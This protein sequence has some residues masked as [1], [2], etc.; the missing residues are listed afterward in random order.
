MS[1]KLDNKGS[2][3]YDSNSNAHFIEKV[4]HLSREV[5]ET[6]MGKYSFLKEKYCY[7]HHKFHRTHEAPKGT[8][9]IYVD[10][11]E[12]NLCIHIYH[13]ATNVFYLLEMNPS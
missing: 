11:L 13:V 3:S 1:L 7:T 2:E 12:A 4:T 8:L 10:S 9:V 5:V 6:F